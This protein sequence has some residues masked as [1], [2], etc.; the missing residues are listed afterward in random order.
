[1][2]S[3]VGDQLIADPRVKM[4]T[5]TGSTKTGRHLAVEAA[6]HLKKFTLEMGGKSPL[7]V[8]AD[9]DLDYA[10]D[11]AAFGVYLHQGQVCMASS[12]VIVEAPLFDAF[13]ES[14]KSRPRASRS[15]P[16]GSR[17]RHRAAHPRAPVRLHRGPA[18]G[19]DREGRQGGGGRDL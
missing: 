14:S 15:G 4:I 9:A 12:K 16:E 19:R 17:D 18:P 1:M 13:V 7:I 11:A 6:K 2:P 3:E 8:L 5:F 10:V